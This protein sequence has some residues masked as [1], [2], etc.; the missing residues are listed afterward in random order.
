MSDYILKIE[1]VEKHFGGLVALHDVSFNVK[2]NNITGLIG[3][4]GAGKT[5]L[6]NALSGVYKADKGNIFF[7][8]ND[9]I[10][11][12]PHKIADIGIARTF[13]IAR[14]FLDLTVIENVLVGL[15]EKNYRGFIKPF[16]LS[17]RKDNIKKAHDI[18]DMVGI[19]EFKKDFWN[20]RLFG[21]GII[22]F[23][24]GQENLK[25]LH[26]NLKGLKK[27]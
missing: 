18:L 15:G 20:S 11:M 8:S 6:F 26:Y 16:K 5:T 25:N 24:D 21:Y 10:N 17:K 22:E 13:Q 19:K 27:I 1:N 23:I 7:N 2:E 12:P 4:N 9:I 3:P 14:P